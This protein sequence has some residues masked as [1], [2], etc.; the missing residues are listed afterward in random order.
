MHLVPC[1]PIAAGSS[2]KEVVMCE[3][4]TPREAAELL[5]VDVQT[6]RKLC[7]KGI[8]P[9]RDVGAGRYRCWRMTRAALEAWLEGR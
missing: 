2:T 9:A 7:E 4:L 6:I 5:K 1:I 8:I 3:V